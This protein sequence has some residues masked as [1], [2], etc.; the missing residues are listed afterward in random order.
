MAAMLECGL[1]GRAQLLDADVVH[2]EDA[3]AVDDVGDRVDAPDLVGEGAA[4]AHPLDD[5]DIGLERGAEAED[6]DVS[7]PT[8]GGGNAGRARPSRR[9]GRDLEG[10]G[11]SS[12]GGS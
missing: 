12:G 2:V 11:G 5:V 10:I 6:D 3:V 4:R 1:G 8:G 7:G 9:A